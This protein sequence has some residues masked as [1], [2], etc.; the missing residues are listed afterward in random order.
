MARISTLKVVT[1]AVRQCR[2]IIDLGAKAGLASLYFEC[3]YPGVRILAV[4]PVPETVE[5]L[6]TNLAHGIQAGRHKVLHGAASSG[7]RPR[8]QTMQQLIDASGFG[9][10]DLLKVDMDGGERELFRG[11][12]RWLD[13]VRSIAIE[14]HDTSREDIGF[15]RLMRV[16]GF[17]IV[18]ENRHTVVATRS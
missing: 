9:E 11:H 16:Y 15:D 5:V 8:G 4:E 2:T 3:V 6:K 7:D 12:L 1:D 17:E 10:V 18:A 14:F 13:R